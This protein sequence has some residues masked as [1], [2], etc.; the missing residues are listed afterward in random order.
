MID[1]ELGHFCEQHDLSPS[2]M[3]GLIERYVNNAEDEDFVP[4][5]MKTMNEEHFFEQMHAC[6]SESSREDAALETV[7]NEE[8]GETSLS[9]IWFLNPESIDKDDLNKW[10][11]VLGMPWPFRKLFQ[12]AHKKPMKCII[13]HVPASNFDIS[14]SIPFFGN[15]AFNVKLGGD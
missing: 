5:F 8:K 13:R 4:L 7:Q 3:F 14:I 11:S 1:E 6:A 12:S 10:L 9:G 15:V 2:D